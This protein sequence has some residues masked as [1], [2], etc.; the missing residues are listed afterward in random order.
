M[1]N[2][3]IV[4]AAP[5]VPLGS[6]EEHNVDAETAANL[7]GAL[8]PRAIPE[9]LSVGTSPW[10]ASFV[11][12]LVSLNRFEGLVEITLVVAVGD[13]PIE[14]LPLKPDGL[15]LVHLSGGDELAEFW[16]AVD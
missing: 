16:V 3:K 5:P 12:R 13:Q 15:F 14:A 10:R 6:S 7:A 8:L 1:E 11:Q 2:M 4:K 9:D